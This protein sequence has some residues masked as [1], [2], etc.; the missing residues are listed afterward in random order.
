MSKLLA[1][2]IAGLFAAGAYAQNPPGT[3]SQE[4]VITNTKPQ[5]RA[6]DRADARPQGEVKKPTGDTA[7]SA[8]SDAIGTGKAATAGQARVETRD[9]RHP[10]RK[11][12][13]QG[14]T[15]DMPGAK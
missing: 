15:P 1:A 12:S 10:N 6:Q 13:K 4:Q 14:G 8:Q 5:Q 2:M 3:T 11:Q 9:E 7:A